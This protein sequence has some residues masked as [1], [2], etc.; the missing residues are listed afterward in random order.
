MK[1]YIVSLLF[2]LTWV[3]LAVISV[4]Q[5]KIIKKMKL[6]VD[7]DVGQFKEMFNSLCE[8]G[9]DVPIKKG[10]FLSKKILNDTVNAPFND[11]YINVS[12]P[13]QICENSLFL[14]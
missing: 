8:T 12:I 1:W 10:Q 13:E 7:D 9:I 14:N 11:T 4:S 6:F 5:S 3:W 2:V